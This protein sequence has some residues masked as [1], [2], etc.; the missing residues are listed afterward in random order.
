MKNSL[1][2]P[3]PE[4]EP[5]NSS[6]RSKDAARKP[7]ALG[8]REAAQAIGISRATLYRHIKSG[9]IPAHKCGERTLLLTSEI[10]HYLVNLPLLH[11]IAPVNEKEQG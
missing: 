6:A 9:L 2:K 10:E 3:L 8:V 5:S 11:G 1:Y 4:T 7:L